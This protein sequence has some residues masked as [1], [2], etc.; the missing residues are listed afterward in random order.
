MFRFVFR[1][2]VQ[3]IPTVVI[4]TLLLFLAMSIMRGSA[5]DVF[6]GVSADRTPEATQ[7]LEAQLG[8][9]KPLPMQYLTWLA[10]VAHGDFGESWRLQKPVLPLILSR[11][12]VSLE[13][14]LI[15]SLTSLILSLILGTFLATHKDSFADQ[16]IRIIGLVFISAPVFWVAIGLILI[17]STYFNW[18]P[19]IQ[20]VGFREDPIEN[21]KIVLIPSLLWGFLSVPS[22][23]RYV[24]NAVLDAIGADYVRTARAKGVTERAILQRHVLRNAAGPLVT[25]VGLSLGAAAGGTLLLESV[26]TL[27]GMGR[28]WLSAISQR[29]FPLILG[30]GV[31]VSTIFVLVNLITDISYALFDPRVRLR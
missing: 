6:F 10:G 13:V 12:S 24:R 25:V 1:R 16:A 3:A 15:A 28:L 27:P 9:D 2:L 22:F 11:L 26:F 23:S 14:A 7:K 5:V 17:L 18:I 8:L 19:P 4:S 29:D 30:I 21:L 31:V 20:Y